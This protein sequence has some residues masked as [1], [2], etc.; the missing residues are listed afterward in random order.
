MNISN[1]AKERYIE[2]I[3]GIRSKAEIKQYLAQ[4]E[5]RVE[6]H[7]LKL[8]EYSELIFTGQV[9]GDKTTRDFHLN[10]DVCLVVGNNCINTIYLINFAFPEKTRQVVIADLKEEI[11]RLQDEIEVETE[12]T[13][14][15]KL[16]FDEK[17]RLVEQEIK[18]LK[19]SIEIKL[20]EIK[21]YETEKNLL[22]KKLK[23]YHTC[24]QNYA[25]Q[26]FG[27]TEYKKDIIVE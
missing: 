18:T 20:D 22:S 9:G 5:D 15:K 3:K 27:N 26:L 4:N 21:I 12:N 7:I 8:Y 17:I 11:F 2:R 19:E 16:E 6:E 10:G 14:V 13:N 1:H 23:Q 24:L 25:E